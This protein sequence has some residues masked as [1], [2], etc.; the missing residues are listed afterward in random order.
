MRLTG[1]CRKSTLY[2]IGQSAWC[3]MITEAQWHY[4]RLQALP[5]DW[6]SG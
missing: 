1:L 3:L 2:R 4:L 6:V 5:G